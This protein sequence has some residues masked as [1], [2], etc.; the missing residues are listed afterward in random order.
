MPKPFLTYDQ[1]LQKLRDKHMVIH[2]DAD[3]KNILHR[4]SYFALI[5]G[6]KDLLKNPTTKNYK[7][8]TC[9]EDI[10]ALYQFDEQLRELTLRYLLHIERHIRSVLSYAFC[11]KFGE[12]QASYLSLQNFDISFASNAYEVRN[13]IGK[14]LNPLIMRPTK[15]PY[16]EHHKQKHHNV[17]LWV[18]VNALTF[19]TI[20]KMYEY[21][22]P[23][24]KSVVSMEFDGINE[25]QLQMILEVLTDFRNVCAHNERLFTHRCAKHDIP[26]LPLHSKLN[27]PKN[28]QEYKFGKRDYF[29][30][31]LAFRYM[32][33]NSDF[34]KYKLQLSK[35]ADKIVSETQQITEQELYN[36]VSLPTHSTEASEN[37]GFIQSCC[38]ANTGSNTV[39]DGY[40]ITLTM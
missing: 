26:D 22:K 34:L 12:G 35:L 6:Y 32:L 27:L 15:Y 37:I 24:V 19:G 31:V 2:D 4:Y 17:P 5:T 9:L 7:D 23:Q 8:G 25:S 14:Y 11:D 18:L 40:A 3:A 28:G 39:Q 36:T 16:I 21:S 29:S 33:P 20:S 30:V 1:Q 10:V 13:L 38:F